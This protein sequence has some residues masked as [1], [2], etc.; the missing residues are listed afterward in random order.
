MKRVI[1]RLCNDRSVPFGVIVL[2]CINVC[3][4][5]AYAECNQLENCEVTADYNN[6]NCTCKV[7]W[8]DCTETNDCFVVEVELLLFLIAQPPKDCYSG[9][10]ILEKGESVSDLAAAV[11]GKEAAL[12]PGATCDPAASC[13]ETGRGGGDHALQLA[14]KMEDAGIFD[15]DIHDLFYFQTVDAISVD[16][17]TESQ[18]HVNFQLRLHTTKPP[19]AIRGG[20]TTTSDLDDGSGIVET[21]LYFEV[22]S[23][24]L[25]SVR[26]LNLEKF[27]E[28]EFL[29]RPNPGLAF[30]PRLNSPFRVLIETDA[31]R[32]Y[33]F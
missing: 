24:Q 12:T 6:L 26:K 11:D 15:P 25:L 31:K 30:C 32:R 19:S 27:L 17:K 23:V 8:H 33:T 10:L 18:V 1:S 5:R 13:C 9:A 20:V 28:F 4:I 14:A 21:L 16:V 3:P 7:K 2:L 29:Q 22:P